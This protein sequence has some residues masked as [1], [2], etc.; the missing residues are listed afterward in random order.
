MASATLAFSCSSLC[1]TLKLPQNLNPLLLNVPPLS[2]PFSGVVSPPSLSRLSLLPVAAKRR[3]FQEIP[4]ELKAEFEEFQRPPN[5]KPQLS[6]VLPDD[7]QAPEPGT[8]EYNDIINQF[9]PKKGP[10]PPREEIFA[11]V[12]IGSRQYI[13]IPGRWIYTQRLKGATVN[14]KIVLNKVLLVGT[15]ASTYI[16]TPIVT[17]AA[18]HAV[19]EEQLLDDKVIVFK[20]KKKKN[21]RRNIGH[22][23][24]ITRIKI[25]GITGYEDYPASTL[26]AEVEAKEEAEAEAEAE[27]VPV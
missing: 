16:G 9:L 17:N 26:E 15:K 12:V 21:Y 13:V 1:A 3:R 14:D 6:D 25:T 2:K 11:V 27:A 7:F 8:P 18:V 22:R 5:Q 10:P 24:P 23:Q 19:V 4:E 20:Y